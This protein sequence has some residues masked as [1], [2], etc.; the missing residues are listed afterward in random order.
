MACDIL[1]LPLHASR[2]PLVNC[3][4]QADLWTGSRVFFVV[5]AASHAGLHFKHFSDNPHHQ[6]ADAWCPH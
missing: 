2:Y 6:L 3:G 4:G 5:H 1:G